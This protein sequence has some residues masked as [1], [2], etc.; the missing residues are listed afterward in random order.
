MADDEDTK[1]PPVAQIAV[2]PLGGSGEH[3]LD[4][5]DINLLAIQPTALEADDEF[6]PFFKTGS[7]LGDKV[8]IIQPPYN[9]TTLAGLCQVNN[10][11]SPAI[12]AMVNNIDGTGYSIRLKDMEDDDED[13]G[14]SGDDDSEEDDDGDT[15]VKIKQE[16]IEAFFDEVFPQMSFVTVRKKLRRDLETS[17]NAYMEVLRNIKGDLVFL[18]YVRA[19]DVRMVK[20]D[21][22]ITKDVEIVRNGQRTT[23]AMMATER[24]YAQIVG[25]K[26]V[27]FKEMNASRELHKTEGLWD[28]S[29]LLSTEDHVVKPEDRAN[30][31]IH[32]TN[33]P[34]MR[35]PYGI[36]RWIPQLPSVLGSRKAEEH[37]LEFF[38]SGGIPPV[39]VTIAGGK[40][41]EGGQAAIDNFFSGR[42]K[43]KQRGVVMEILPI[44]GTLE[45]EASGTKVE[46]H[47]FGAEQVKDSM[48]EEYDNKCEKRVR[49]S[50]RLPP[51]F[52][53]M[54]ED[55]SFA[56]A[57]ASYTVAEAQ[58]FEPE[59]EE[60]DEMVNNLIMPELDPEGLFEFMSLPITVNDTLQRLDAIKI[61]LEAGGIDAEGVIEALNDL[62]NLDLKF[63]PDAKQNVTD[64]SGTVVNLPGDQVTGAASA[65]GNV[66]PGQQS[67]P[68]GP[69]AK[70]DNIIDIHAADHGKKKSK[71][72]AAEFVDM[73]T[74]AHAIMHAPQDGPGN[75][76]ALIAVSQEVAGLDVEE[77]QIFNSI[78]SVMQFDSVDNDPSGL[79]RMAGC[80]LAVLAAQVT[81]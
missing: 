7:A 65:S 49:R 52:V 60:F 3:P 11:L 24:R 79:A 59:R 36:P 15:E 20:L 78:L 16:K 34:D 23:V 76:E 42:S 32:L 30:E 37:N 8:D 51:L 50:F 35:S 29:D 70:S 80:S 74:R 33:I 19:K 5:N 69:T 53:G 71:R 4:K 40:A 61:A 6:A 46:V 25:N 39:L 75:A 22:P 12:E 67:A 72:K 55:F 48:F 13:D 45:K 73:A 81:P 77:L 63:D 62:V 38:D 58:V 14:E 68:A 10:A 9:L 44:G 1:S 18:R 2:R 28:G 21:A 41:A 66:A 57:F 56:T 17:G 27:F 64:I 47:R 43:N 31:L 54:A 26:V